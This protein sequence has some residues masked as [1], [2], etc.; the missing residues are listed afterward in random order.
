V[1]G[2]ISASFGRSSSWDWFANANCLALLAT[3]LARHVFGSGASNI[4]NSYQPFIGMHAHLNS[5][6]E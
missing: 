2:L 1:L 4:R 3:E 6:C 5:D